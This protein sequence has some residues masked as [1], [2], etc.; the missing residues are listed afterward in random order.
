MNYDIIIIGAGIVGCSI[1]RELSSYN[2]SVVVLEKDNDVSVGTTKA[3]SGIAHAGF[4][5]KV[6]TLKAKFNVLGNKMMPSLSN[7]LDFPF[8]QN[9]AIVLGFEEESLEILKDLLNRGIAS[10]VERLK[11]ISKDEILKL[12]PNVNPNVKYGLL[13]PTSG[14]VSPYEMAIAYAENASSNG[15]RFDFNSEVIRIER[16][17][18]EYVVTTASNK[19]YVSKVIIN[20]AG[21]YSDKIHSLASNKKSPFTVISRKGEYCLLDK[22]YGDMASHT[23]FQTPSKLGKGVLVTPTTHGNLLVGPNAQDEVDNANVDTTI[24]GLKE[25]WDK[26]SLTMPNLPKR[27]VITQFAGLRSHLKESDDFIIGF[28]NE[29]IGFYDVAGIES[30]GLTA[31]PAIAKHV[32]KEIATYLNLGI[33]LHFNPIRKAIPQISALP[34]EVREKLIKENPLYGH[35][36]CRCEVV[37]EGEIVEAIHRVPGAKDLDGIKRRT[38]AGMGRCQMGFCTPKIME[39]LAREL[40][41]DIDEITKNGHHSYMVEKR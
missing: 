37:S 11:I 21:V 40:H 27:G 22:M 8:K 26:A 25:I 3:N 31:A 12:E 28:D 41:E 10:G 33:N 7:D 18:N 1:A 29:L 4:D 5:A 2:G 23:L 38:R 20:C 6:G 35:I 13:A 15:V 19:T 9:G 34:N 30:P 39:I 14:I 36:I 32:S 24:E 16:N 17:K